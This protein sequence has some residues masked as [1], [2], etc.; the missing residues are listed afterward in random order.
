MFNHHLSLG[1]ESPLI[2][3][4]GFLPSDFDHLSVPDGDLYSAAVI[5]KGTPGENFPRIILLHGSDLLG[6]IT[7]TLQKVAPTDSSGTREKP[8]SGTS[9]TLSSIA[10]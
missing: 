2:K 6:K 1:A 8:C 5:A 9:E 10:Q 7:L 3:G 4:M